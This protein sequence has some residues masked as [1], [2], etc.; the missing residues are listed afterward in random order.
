M[1]K[2][3]KIILFTFLLVGMQQIT[4]QNYK[5]L[6]TGFT[7]SEK[8]GK[9]Q[10]SKW[11]DLEKTSIIITVDTKKDR[12]I[13]YSQEIQLY[14]IVNYEKVEENENGK[15]Y[16]FTCSDED[17]QPFTISIIMRKDQDNRKQLYVKHKNA[18]IAYN[19]ETY[20]DEVKKLGH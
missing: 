10:W 15:I 16:P 11:S 13:I 4:S 9:G 19:I 6:A 20:N 2:L 3:K 12:I 7:V 8:N 5:F 1:N 14:K 18:I 17:G